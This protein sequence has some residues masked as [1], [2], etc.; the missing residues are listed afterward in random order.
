M[1][2]LGRNIGEETVVILPDGRRVTV[3]IAGLDIKTGRVK[4]GFM[5]PK[6]IEIERRENL[7]FRDYKGWEGD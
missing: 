1:L 2:V 3:V 6:D 7:K 5:A 4:L